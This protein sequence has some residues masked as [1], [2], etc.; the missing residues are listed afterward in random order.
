[1]YFRVSGRFEGGVP[2]SSAAAERRRTSPLLGHNDTAKLAAKRP[3]EEEN[4]HL[5]SSMDQ[6]EILRPSTSDYN[7]VF[8][9]IKLS[10]SVTR[11]QCFQVCAVVRGHG[12]EGL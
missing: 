1:M 7:F 9:N 11:S 12:A 8:P 2:S 4:Q 10:L 5:E 3:Q 6:K